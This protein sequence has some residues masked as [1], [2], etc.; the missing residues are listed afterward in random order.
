[1]KPHVWFLATLMA[2]ACADEDESRAAVVSIAQA[3]ADEEAKC[4]AAVEDLS[5]ARA[6]LA[7]HREALHTVSREQ[8]SYAFET[9]GFSVTVAELSY[10]WSDLRLTVGERKAEQVL[11]VLFEVV[12]NGAY[13]NMN[14]HFSTRNQAAPNSDKGTSYSALPLERFCNAQGVF[15]FH[16]EAHQTSIRMGN[17]Y[18]DWPAR[19]FSWKDAT[20]AL[21]LRAEWSDYEWSF[22]AC[23]EQ[24]Y[25]WTAQHVE[26]LALMR[27]LLN[28]PNL[29]RVYHELAFPTEK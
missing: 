19:H 15:K 27:P 1:M 29:Y 28:E 22:Q 6:G 21:S 24:C 9:T 18:H 23:N 4:I 8:L 13:A 12:E 17:G 14:A 11:G 25:E 5:W 3:M 16:S 20:R 2:T 26:G 7:A 10:Y